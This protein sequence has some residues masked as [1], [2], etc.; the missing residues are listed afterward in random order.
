MLTDIL[1]AAH[2][3]SVSSSTFFPYECLWICCFRKT[4]SFFSRSDLLRLLP[5]PQSFKMTMK[6][7]ESGRHP[8]T[9]VI[10]SGGIMAVGEGREGASS[11]V[12][13]A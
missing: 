13:N 6:K 3:I 12:V 7:V 9:P 10:Q 4:I 1:N 5:P 11:R 8:D 2:I